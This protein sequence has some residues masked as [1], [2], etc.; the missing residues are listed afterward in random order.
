MF[1]IAAVY[2]GKQLFT[3]VI[4]SHKTA[5]KIAILDQTRFIKK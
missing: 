5:S 2:G 4:N 3:Y 1:K